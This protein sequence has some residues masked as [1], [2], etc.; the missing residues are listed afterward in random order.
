MKGKTH[1]HP[2]HCMANVSSHQERHALY[3]S[4]GGCYGHTTALTLSLSLYAESSNGPP[5]NALALKGF[6]KGK[7][8]VAAVAWRRGRKEIQTISLLL[9][10]RSTHYANSLP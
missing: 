5:R 4:E 7:I 3:G 10:M 8:R 9:A 2:P 6:F 1:T